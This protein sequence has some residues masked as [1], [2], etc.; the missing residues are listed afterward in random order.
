MLRQKIRWRQAYSPGG[1]QE[2]TTGATVGTQP[3]AG[4]IFAV[5]APIRWTGKDYGD[6]RL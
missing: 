3:A 1:Q 2:E 4:V 5:R 6:L